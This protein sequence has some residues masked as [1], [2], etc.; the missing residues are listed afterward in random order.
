MNKYMT[1]LK[2]SPVHVLFASRRFSVGRWWDGAGFMLSRVFKI[3]RLGPPGLA[4]IMRQG[5]GDLYILYGCYFPLGQWE[6][7]GSFVSFQGANIAS[8]IP[9][10]GLVGCG[11]GDVCLWERRWRMDDWPSNRLLLG[12]DPGVFGSFQVPEKWQSRGYHHN[13]LF[14]AVTG[15]IGGSPWARWHYCTKLV[16]LVCRR[17]I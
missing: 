11:E 12:V 14:A 2:Q 8:W 17:G 1:F 15:S 4:K 7:H 3:L 16:R 13:V 9:F 10:I 6:L 5:N